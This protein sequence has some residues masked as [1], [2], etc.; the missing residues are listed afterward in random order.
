M[1]PSELARKS[2]SL[3]LNP[4]YNSLC[5]VAGFQVPRDGLISKLTFAGQFRNSSGHLYPQLHIWRVQE[6]NGSSDIIYERVLTV[7]LF[8][9]PE[10]TSHLNVYEYTMNPPVQVRQGH[11]LGYYQPSSDTSRL[12]LVTVMDLGPKSHC[13]S[14][15]NPDSSQTFNTQSNSVAELSHAPLIAINYGKKTIRASICQYIKY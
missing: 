12:V 1:T 6:G 8:T 7:G 4:N 2:L 10:F 11:V 15:A 9:A 5:V 14:G 13:L 3:A